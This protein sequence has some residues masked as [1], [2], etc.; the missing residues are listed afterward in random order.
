[1]KVLGQ[2]QT[3]INELTGN[4]NNFNEMLLAN[5]S[6]LIATVRFEK[7][8]ETAILSETNLKQ[9][10]C[11]PIP[12]YEAVVITSSLR[13]CVVN[14]WK[15]IFIGHSNVSNLTGIF[16]R[17]FVSIIT[18][19]LLISTM[20]I[21]CLVI[22][23]INLFSTYITEYYPEATLPVNDEYSEEAGNGEE[24]NQEI[25]LINLEE[26]G[27][28]LLQDLMLSMENLEEFPTQLLTEDY[29]L[30]SQSS[31]ISGNIEYFDDWLA[32]E[33]TYSNAGSL[34]RIENQLFRSKAIP[35]RSGVPEVEKEGNLLDI[36]GVLE[37]NQKENLQTKAKRPEINLNKTIV[38]SKVVIEEESEK[39]NEYTEYHGNENRLKKAILHEESTNLPLKTFE[40]LNE[41]HKTFNS[42]DKTKYIA[43]NSVRNVYPIRK[44]NS[45]VLPLIT[46]DIKSEPDWQKVPDFQ[47]E[48]EALSILKQ[49]NANLSKEYEESLDYKLSDQ[50]KM[51]LQNRVDPTVFFDSKGFVSEESID[52]DFKYLETA[53]NEN[54]KSLNNKTLEMMRFMVQNE[55]EG[56]D[57][58]VLQYTILIKA[59]LPKFMEIIND[60]FQAGL[61]LLIRDIFV[62]SD[63]VN[64]LDL[65]QIISIGLLN[66]ESLGYDFIVHNLIIIVTALNYSLFAEWAK[67]YLNDTFKIM[68]ENTQMVFLT[69]YKYWVCFNHDKILNDVND[70]MELVGHFV[71]WLSSLIHVG[72]Q[73]T[74]VISQNE[75]PNDKLVDMLVEIYLCF[76]ELLTQIILPHDLSTIILQHLARF[77][78]LL[79]P[80]KTKHL[81][82]PRTKVES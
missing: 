1:M 11:A 36:I 77:F 57:V 55:Y 32:D 63:E 80:Y 2:L 60:E 73:G 68:T 40:I 64:L 70:L 31:N 82:A 61:F 69:I 4:L 58:G 45:I 39:E 49:W 26:F 42:Y 17:T 59:H 37:N 29:H 78:E 48:P 16:T 5:S 8:L 74:F 27:D 67:N 66:L 14:M 12:P 9:C 6:K 34:E 41:F 28:G 35:N 47:Q 56:D 81:L 33:L 54:L 46:N 21:S 43:D 23:T 30:R 79:G 15:I 76:N 25:G 71:S 51:I 62:F 44:S 18:S 38:S 52:C 65:N 22:F 10:E 19:D 24:A 75:F 53:F 20:F 3:W 72:K 50:L 7:T 13:D